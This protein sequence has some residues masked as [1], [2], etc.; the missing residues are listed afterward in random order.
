[1]N[2]IWIILILRDLRWTIAPKS[3]PRINA[4]IMRAKGGCS[5]MASQRNGDKFDA[6]WR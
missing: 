3:L 4:A 2:I 1:M 6:A 5:Y